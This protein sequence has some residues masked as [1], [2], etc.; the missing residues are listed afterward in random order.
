ML[1]SPL[2]DTATPTGKS[3]KLPK[4]PLP[5][6]PPVEELDDELLELEL[7]LLDEVVTPARARRNFATL[8]VQVPV[9]LL[10]VGG[11]VAI[12]ASRLVMWSK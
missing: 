6:P 3:T 7:E 2:T 4:A 12:S 5:V 10:P 8:V 11:M 9:H 1:E